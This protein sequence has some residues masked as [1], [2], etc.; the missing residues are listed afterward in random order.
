MEYAILHRFK[1]SKNDNIKCWLS[2]V[3][4]FMSDLSKHVKELSDRRTVLW[5][6]VWQQLILRYRR[7][8]LGY[9]WSLINPL[10]MMSIM[11]VV[12]ATLFKADLKTFT[13]FLFTGMIPWNFFSSVV[14]Q[15]SSAFINNEGLIKKIYL[16]KIIF[17]LSI[18]LS[19]LVDSALSFI[20]L[21]IIILI[22][23]GTLSWAVF[24][25][26]I[27]YLI[28]FFFA[29][30]ISLVMSVITVFFRDL[31]HIIVIAMQGLFFLTPIFY[32]RDAITGK[33]QFLVH[34]NP[35]TTFI[36]LFRSPLYHATLPALT[37][38]L[39]AVALAVMAMT[40]GLFFFLKQQKKVIFRL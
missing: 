20:T 35:I 11:A 34:L 14:I 25:I 23:G 18:C 33:A 5:I 32:K 36:D 15:S 22:I 39:K 38:I 28:L 26:P 30:G 6:L 7:T 9:L 29:F 21:F 17:P 1:P 12:F 40:I 31:Q 8:L 37:V 2:N 4:T 24:F 27:A 3:G 10:L 19:L 13:V 16:P